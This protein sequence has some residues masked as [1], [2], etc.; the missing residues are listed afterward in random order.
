MHGFLTRRDVVIASLAA[1][2]A[3]AARAAAPATVLP[4]FSSAA[5]GAAEVPGWQHQLLP[6]VQRSNE[7]QIVDEG[8]QRVLRVRS[9]A[10]ASSW[11]AR[12]PGSLPPASVLQWRWKVSR[13]LAG[14][15]LR[16][17][18]GDDY[19]ARLYVL[20]DLPLERLALGDR[21]RLQ[22]A[23]AISGADLPAA[24][25]C[26]VWG[27]AQAPGSSG[28]NP[29]TDRLRMVVV[30]SGDALAGQW[31]PARRDLRSDWEAAFGG[32][33]PRVGAIAV[34][35]DTDNTGETVEAWFGDVLLQEAS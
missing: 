19:A 14:S 17:K 27:R 21:L 34:G 10:S 3:L 35:A 8:G 15:D 2:L 32:P 20:F 6:K 22:A 12:V 24:A 5:T 33:M 16:S 31:R 11:L 29:Y 4:R 23:R 25:I 13:A 26:Y 30:D 28:W 9:E 18:P 7:F 1:P